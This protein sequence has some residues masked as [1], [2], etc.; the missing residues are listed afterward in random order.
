LLRSSLLVQ[1]YLVKGLGEVT[2]AINVSPSESSGDVVSVD[3]LMGLGLDEI[4]LD[5]V[6]GHVLYLTDV[7]SGGSGD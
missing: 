6:L 1:S 7:S 4:I 3:V 2:D 5:C